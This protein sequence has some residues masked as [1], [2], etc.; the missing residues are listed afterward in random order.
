MIG[1]IYNKVK[2]LSIAALA[3]CCLTACEDFLD[4]PSQSS[5]PAENAYSK[6]ASIDMNLTGVYG[7]LKPF[8]TYYFVMSEFRSDNMF[9]TTE[10]KTNQYADCAQFNAVGLL[11]DN[12]I[13]SCWADHYKL[14]AAAN[15]LLD[16]MGEATDLT[17][18]TAT[19][20]QAEARFLRALSY[21]DLVRFFGRVP[22]SLHEMTPD[23]AFQLPQS[24]ASDIYDQIIIP[25]LQFAADNLADQA[26]DYAGAS[27]KERATKNAAKALLGKV[28]MQRAGYPF[29]QLMSDAQVQQYNNKAKA[30]FKEILANYTQYWAAT[31]DDWNRMWIHENDN[32]YFI[33][34]I[35]YIAE[36]NQGNPAAWL[37]R[38]SN[39]QADYFCGANLTAGPHIYVERG[40]QN[41]FL[42]N[43]NEDADGNKEYIDKRFYNTVNIAEYLDEEDNQ[44]KGG[45]TDGNNFCSKFF[46]HKL[47]RDSLGYSDMDATIIDR[48][49]WP[50]NWPVLRVE[51][52]MLLYAELE[53][54]T[55]DGYKYLNLIRQ[56]AG[57]PAVS[58]LS[59]EVFLER[60]AYERRVELLG[61]GHRWFDQVRHNTFVQEI[62]DMMITYRDVYDS[63]HNNNYLIYANRVTQNSALYPI[64]LSQMRVR[65]GLYQQNPGY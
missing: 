41:Y 64:P 8:A 28:Y 63:S 61:E 3:V 65:E 47:K 30:L 39:N 44:V 19:Q 45:V 2:G 33:F 11:G 59:K 15:T 62:R 10:S 55:T 52:V 1:N 38:G 26:V 22:A 17:A 56:R 9:E 35:Q 32:K 5:I 31:A 50:Q 58:E 18:A 6:A 13:A 29:N 60:V 20:Y 40:L 21:F 25:D 57:L 7:A 24:E 43:Y 42:S 23:E 53:G 48:T 4:T 14:I 12:L 27:H 46:E 34:E 54:N 16:R 51:D 49:C 37:S 36:K